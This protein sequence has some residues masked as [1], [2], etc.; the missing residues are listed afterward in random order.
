MNMDMQAAGMPGGMT[1]T[2]KA[3]TIGRRTGDCA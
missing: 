1:M 2:I 3:R